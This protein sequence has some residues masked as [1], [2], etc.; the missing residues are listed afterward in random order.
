MKERLLYNWSIQRLFYVL[1]GLGIIS[2]SIAEK[3]WMGALLGGYFLS[4]GVFA[5]GCAAP[6]GC[7]TGRYSS[8]ARQRQVITDTEYEEIK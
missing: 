2:G 5:F 3:E 7:N 6:G 1:M 4:M 8:N